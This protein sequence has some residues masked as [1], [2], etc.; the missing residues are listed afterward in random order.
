MDEL[1]TYY[2]DVDYR[3]TDGISVQSADCMHII[4]LMCKLRHVPQSYP[5]N[6]Y[7]CVFFDIGFMSM[8]KTK[9]VDWMDCNKSDF[10][11]QSIS[12][13]W[14]PLIPYKRTIIIVMM[15]TIFP[16]VMRVDH[17]ACVWSRM[18]KRFLYDAWVCCG[19][20][21]SHLLSP[22]K[23]DVAEPNYTSY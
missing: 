2:D 6:V 5:A 22:R 3:F 18:T 4:Q 14:G 7:L 15:G 20:K 13:C 21:V 9:N 23:T 17:D 16:I 10:P 11:E 8:L 12:V 19:A 1:C